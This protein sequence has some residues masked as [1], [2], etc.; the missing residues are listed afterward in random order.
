M[1]L[2]H[3]EL[4]LLVLHHLNL[5]HLIEVGV[6]DGP[7]KLEV[8]SRAPCRPMLVLAKLL[9]EG[10]ISLASRGLLMVQTLVRVGAWLRLARHPSWL[11][12]TTIVKQL[13]DLLSALRARRFLTARWLYLAVTSCMLVI[14]QGLR[15]YASILLLWLR[16]SATT[17]FCWIPYWHA[18]ACVMHTVA[19]TVA[20]VDEPNWGT[21]RWDAN[22]CSSWRSFMSYVWHVDRRAWILMTGI[23]CAHK[24]PMMPIIATSLH[25][26]LSLLVLVDKL[27]VKLGHFTSCNS[28]DATCMICNAS[29]VTRIEGSTR[30]CDIANTLYVFGHVVIDEHAVKFVAACSTYWAVTHL[31][32]TQISRAAFLV[33]LLPLVRWA[34][35]YILGVAGHATLDVAPCCC[36]NTRGW[37]LTRLLSLRSFRSIV[38]NEII[39]PI[40]HDI[41]LIATV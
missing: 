18:L 33:L 14:L 27:Q 16:L 36:P 17:V 15:R 20:A 3:Q 35:R 13:L 5:F 34:K 29:I 37:L 31:T 8:A 4:L 11:T 32:M 12:R 28:K 21:S 30:T 38:R 10:S 24:V 26:V 9:D 2:L 7:M 41:A 1:L 25:L 6:R 22:F 39:L 40:N 19:I 23:T